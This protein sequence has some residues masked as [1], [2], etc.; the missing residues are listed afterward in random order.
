VSVSSSRPIRARGLRS[1]ASY[2]ARSPRLRDAN[3][4]LT[5]AKSCRAI[6]SRRAST[7]R[8]LA[9]FSTHLRSKRVTN[10]SKEQSQTNIAGKSRSGHKTISA[11]A[12]FALGLNAV[13]AVYTSSPSDFALPNVSRLAELLPHTEAPAQAPQTVVAALN[14]IQSAQKQ[15]LASLQETSSSLQQNVA[16]LQQESSTI[17]LLRQSI[18]DEQA[19]VKNISAQI[20]DEHVD[21][22][23][24]AVLI[25]T[26]ITKVDSLQNSIAPATTSSIP[27]GPARARLVTHKRSARVLSLRD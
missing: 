25:S 10:T 2:A 21:V 3:L 23:K 6:R 12:I 24:M 26:L 20:A 22:K 7:L 13:A 17:G 27:K 15:H 9:I 8:R 5:M 14:D 18:T 4:K 19:D 1:C 11:F 16:L